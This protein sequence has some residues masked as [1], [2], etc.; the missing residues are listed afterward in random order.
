M[1]LGK[2]SGSRQVVII[3]VT[4]TMAVAVAVAVVEQR[5]EEEEEE[6]Y[7]IFKKTRSLR[8]TR[9]LHAS[10]FSNNTKLIY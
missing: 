2:I 6:A 5:E 1:S 10:L 7:L 9:L 4:M 8:E 3:I